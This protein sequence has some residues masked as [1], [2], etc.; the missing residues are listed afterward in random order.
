MLVERP[1]HR[2]SLL[3]QLERTCATD[4]K[5]VHAGRLCGSEYSSAV[6]ERKRLGEARGDKIVSPHICVSKTVSQMKNVVIA[7]QCLLHDFF[8]V[9]VERRVVNPDFTFDKEGVAGRRFADGVHHGIRSAV[10][11]KTYCLLARTQGWPAIVFV[12]EPL[13]NLSA[14]SVLVQAHHGHG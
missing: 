1:Q 5:G 9:F 6:V 7:R 11:L 2:E 14:H 10:K 3:E 8:N 12:E 13:N 4:E